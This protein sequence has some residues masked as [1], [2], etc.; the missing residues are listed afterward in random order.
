MTAMFPSSWRSPTKLPMLL[1]PLESVR[2]RR[3]VRGLVREL[4]DQKRERP[5][6]PSNTSRTLVVNVSGVI[7]F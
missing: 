2:E 1:K 6:A 7:G 3:I 4:A 5:G